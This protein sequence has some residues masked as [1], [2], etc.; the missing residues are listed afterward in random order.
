[1]IDPGILISMIIRPPRAEYPDNTGL[2]EE[3][4]FNGVKCYTKNFEIFNSKGEALKC[5]FVSINM[6]LN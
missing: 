2:E 3:S 6:T 1:M 4:I 5:S